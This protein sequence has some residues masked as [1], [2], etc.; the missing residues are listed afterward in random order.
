MGVLGN[1]GIPHVPP[2][3][4]LHAWM[5]G[6]VFAAFCSLR[7]LLG[8]E[9]SALCSV[10]PRR[11]RDSGIPSMTQKKL[12]FQCMGNINEYHVT[13][14]ALRYHQWILGT[15]IFGRRHPALSDKWLGA[16]LRYSASTSSTSENSR[17]PGVLIPFLRLRCHPTW[18]E[19]PRKN[20]GRWF[21]SE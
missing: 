14:G 17:G 21:S 6:A 2:H 4:K 9:D 5:T 12:W 3:L 10:K 15:R 7:S 13:I 8:L 18:Q 16:H 1:L 11:M 19:N 20:P